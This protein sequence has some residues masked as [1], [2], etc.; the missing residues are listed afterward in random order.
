M[1][2]EGSGREAH[3]LCAAVAKNCQAGWPL[4]SCHTK[5]LYLSGAPYKSLFVC[6]LA[7]PNPTLL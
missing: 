1:D 6:F 2:V 3:P 5:I 4:G 7:S